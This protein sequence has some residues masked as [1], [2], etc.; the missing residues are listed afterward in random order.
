M[1][2]SGFEEQLIE[3]ESEVD[4]FPIA[5]I[6]KNYIVLKVEA[7]THSHYNA[8]FLKL[9]PNSL[10]NLKHSKKDIEAHWLAYKIDI[11]EPSKIS[12]EKL[13]YTNLMKALFYKIFLHFNSVTEATAKEFRS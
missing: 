1:S 4:E 9:T 5:D 3:E 11:R 2:E 12:S 7:Y 6:N 8:L 10:Q 13:E